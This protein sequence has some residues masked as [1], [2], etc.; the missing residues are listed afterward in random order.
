MLPVT[1]SSPP[2]KC[3]AA[4]FSANPMSRRRYCTRASGYRTTPE[5]RQKIAAFHREGRDQLLTHRDL[6]YSIAKPIA[7][8]A[9]ESC[10]AKGYRVSAVVVDRA[11]EVIVAFRGDNAGP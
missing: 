1:A 6:S 10:T 4:C 9:I 8:T 2:A 7:E 5:G 3:Q 11:G